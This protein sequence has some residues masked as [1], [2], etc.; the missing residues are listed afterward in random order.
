MIRT[1]FTELFGVE[2]PIAQGGMQWVGTAELVAPWPTPGRW[3]SSP[4]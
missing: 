3:A 1:R 4:R 2:H